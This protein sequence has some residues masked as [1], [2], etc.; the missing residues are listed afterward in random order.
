MKETSLLSDRVSWVVL[1]PKTVR[2]ADWHFDFTTTADSTSI[3]PLLE[4]GGEVCNFYSQPDTVATGRSWD[5]SVLAPC[6]SRNLYIEAGAL[7]TLSAWIPRVLLN[8]ALNPGSLGEET[9]LGEQWSGRG[10]KDCWGWPRFISYVSV[11]LQLWKRKSVGWELH[12][13]NHVLMVL[14]NLA[15]SRCVGLD[16]ALRLGFH[17]STVVSWEWENELS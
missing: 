8:N 6:V 9:E 13:Q 1:E 2:K 4:M 7:P 10:S 16:E 12:L 3:Q 11:W 17:K 14:G 5:W 15:V